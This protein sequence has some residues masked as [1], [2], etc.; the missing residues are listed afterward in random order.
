M[1]L[2]QEE[3][4]TLLLLARLSIMDAL[5]QRVGDSD[6]PEFP[7]QMRGG[8]FVS[9]YVNQEL[10][11][12]MGTFADHR[13]LAQNIRE[14]APLAATQDH[15]FASITSPEL[16]ELSIELSVL[17]PRR[18]ILDIAELEVG[19]HG[20][21]VEKDGARGTLLPQVATKQSWSAEEFVDHCARNKAGLSPG[22]WKEADLY[23]YEALV[24]RSTKDRHA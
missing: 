9:L 8:V 1:K 24:F 19:R 11:G 15:R 2:N 21:F 13:L 18:R 16:K 14:M 7:G 6:W 12:C 3:K 4:K 10:R 23:V 22:D 17:T 20:I 5:D